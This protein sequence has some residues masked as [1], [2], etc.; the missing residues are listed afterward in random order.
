MLQKEMFKRRVLQQ[1]LDVVVALLFVLLWGGCAASGDTNSGFESVT[2]IKNIPHIAYVGN[3]TL[4]GTVVPDSVVHKDI[5]WTLLEKG[6]TGAILDDNTLLTKSPGTVK[7]RAVITD[8]EGEGIDYIHDFFVI[9]I[10]TS[11]EGSGGGGGG[12]STGGGGGSSSESSEVPSS[13]TPSGGVG[14]AQVAIFYWIDEHDNLTTSDDTPSVGPDEPLPITAK[15]PDEAFPITA[16]VTDYTVM[17]WYLNG[18]DTGQNDT[19]Y[20]FSSSISGKHTVGLFVESKGRLYNTN[21][22][23]TVK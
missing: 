13:G 20:V 12:N 5:I 22:T 11:P 23:I 2:D 4:S 21:I 6:D 9:I 16:Q 8:G 14:S 10:L 15:A 19:T 7:M 3:L 1:P 18:V 17:Q